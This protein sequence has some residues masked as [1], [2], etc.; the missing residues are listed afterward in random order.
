VAYNHN[1][2]K[3]TGVYAGV[4]YA[5]EKID[6]VGSDSANSFVVGARHAF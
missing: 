4:T 3:R 2:S 6:G 1:L 5:K